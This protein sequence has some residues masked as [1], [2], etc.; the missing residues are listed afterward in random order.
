MS[1]GL[2][3]YSGQGVTVSQRNERL[4]LFEPLVRLNAPELYVAEKGLTDAV[5]VALTLGQPLL[6]TGDPGTGK[7]QLAASVACE[8]ELPAPLTFHA[9]TTSTARDLFYRYDALA[10]FHDSHF[11]KEALNVEAYITFEAL[12]QAILLS[13][14][15]AEADRYL[16]ET[17]RGKGPTRSVVLIDEIDKAP[18]DFPNDIL[19]EIEHLSFLVRETGQSFAAGPEYRP[20]LVLTSNSEKNLPDAFLRRCIFYHISFPSRDRLREI[21]TRRLDLDHRLTPQV[22]EH[23]LDH[24]EEIR[25]LALAKRPATAECLAWLRVLQHLQVD[26]KN[27]KPGQAEVLSLSYSVLAKNKDDLNRLGRAFRPKD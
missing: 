8:L 2:R 1:G 3:L 6:V 21:A 27:L 20:I 17:L 14:P 18:R 16:P 11:R 7:T 25:S 24:F 5:N 26:P 10:H 23:A 19:N 13:L 4:P 12:G 22:L 9:K 15:G